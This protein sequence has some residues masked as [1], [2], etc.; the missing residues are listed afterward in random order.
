V[1]IPVAQLAPEH[2][3]RDRTV[4]F[5]GVRYIIPTVQESSGTIVA[6]N[7]GGAIIPV[8]LS[9]Y[10]MVKNGLYVRS[11]IATVIVA[12]VVHQLAT[13]VRG[14]GIRVPIFVPPLVAAVS[15]MFL[16]W[17]RA[18]ALAYIA[19]TFG[20]LIGADLMNLGRLQGLGAPI[21]SIGGAGTFDGIFLTGIIAGLLPPAR[22]R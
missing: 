17:R 20:T 3:V 6:V 12:A 13:P 2:V 22:G 1:N 19:G 18:P 21:A 8:L 4:D 11:V 14:I 10:L 15:A 9:L 5:F 16:S 7:L